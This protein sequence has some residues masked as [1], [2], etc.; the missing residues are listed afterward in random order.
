MWQ[1]E[2]PRQNVG[3]VRG[4]QKSANIVSG[5]STQVSRQMKS[6]DEGSWEGDT[7]PIWYQ[8][9]CQAARVGTN[10]SRPQAR[11]W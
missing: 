6:P 4:M 10:H 11:D 7:K 2:S 3:T 9:C 8:K 1:A 5:F